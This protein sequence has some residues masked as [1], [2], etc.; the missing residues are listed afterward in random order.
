MAQRVTVMAEDESE[1]ERGS[2]PASEYRPDLADTTAVMVRARDEVSKLPPFPGQPLVDRLYLA[3]MKLYVASSEADAA[4]LDVGAL[5][6]RRQLA[7]LAE[8]VRELGDRVFDQGRVLTGQSLLPAGLSRAEVELP[9]PVPDWIAEGLAAGPPIAPA[10]VA[11]VERP[12]PQPLT[13]ETIRRRLSELVR[14]EA[15]LTVV[16]TGELAPAQA[17]PLQALE[18]ELVSAAQT[19]D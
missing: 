15:R 3:S 14:D 10:P 6:L 11:S 17:G 16:A 5:D 7:L 4:S 2:L 19:V 1:W 12:S 9:S 8:R 13:G 18:A